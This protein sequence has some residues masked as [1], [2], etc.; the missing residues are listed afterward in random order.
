MNRQ[1]QKRSLVIGSLLIG[2]A[3]LIIAQMLHILS[4]P[5]A[6]E[7]FTGRK[8]DNNYEYRTIFPPR[9]V[10]YDRNGN[11]MAGNQTVY[12][13]GVD[14]NQNI[15]PEAIAL[16]LN[17]HLGLDY[18]QVLTQIAQAGEGKTYVYLADYIPA[19]K[20]TALKEL[21]ANLEEQAK[22]GATVDSLNGLT[23]SPHLARSYPENDVASNILGFVTRDGHGYFGVEEKYDN[24]LA[25]QPVTVWVPANPNDA[26]EMPD[27]PEGSSIVLTVDREIQDAVEE[28]L[29][30]TLAESGSEA[31][32][33]I[34]LDPKNGEVLA[35]TSSPRMDL[36]EFWNYK[37]YYDNATLF[38]RAV[39]MQYEPGSVFKILTMASAIDNGTVAP[40]T[41][42]LDT[43]SFYYGGAYIHNWDGGGWGEQDMTG[44][45]SHSLNVCLAWVAS[46]LGSNSFYNN[47]QAF[48]IGHPTGIDIAGEGAGRLKL[49]GDDDWYQVDLATNSFG[50][51]VAVTPIQMAMA[52]TALAN[53]GNMVVPHVVRSIITDG[54][55]YNTPTQV[56]GTPISAQ[57]ARTMT[58]MLAQSLE[59]GEGI[60]DV[61]GYR[62]AGKTGTAQ[63]PGPGGYLDNATNASFVG[64]GPVDN[65]QF[66]VYIWLEKPQSSEWASQVAAP[67]FQKVVERLVVLM[68]IPPDEVRQVVAGQ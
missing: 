42:F 50:Q 48:G 46:E 38:N 32:T 63:I 60:A 27:V 59:R 7:V 64:W 44:C 24:L 20:V 14:L 5:R 6:I 67:V 1:F 18:N 36:N 40:T 55:Q 41:S 65:P 25:G 51:G 23:F 29:D 34:V 19:E 26:E 21:Q 13:I 33:I 57:T 22:A 35:M 62:V 49:P 54:R 10:I 68:D 12:E 11:L 31:G 66:L 17:V 9:G 39:S 16:A 43:G 3:V 53:D 47:M 30:T 56:I 37:S 45:M 52:A 61:P 8:A 4:D 15:N 28:V 2:A 58:E